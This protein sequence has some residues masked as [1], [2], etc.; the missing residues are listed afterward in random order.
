MNKHVKR[1]VVGM[2]F[3]LLVIVGIGVFAQNTVNSVGS[4]PLIFS[5]RFTQYRVF[6]CMRYPAFPN[7]GENFTISNFSPALDDSADN[8]FVEVDWGTNYDR[9]IML[10]KADNATDSNISIE[11]NLYES[12]G[13]HVGVVSESGKIYYTFGNGFVYISDKMDYGYA[14]FTDQDYGYGGSI[15][16]VAESSAILSW[17]E[18]SSFEPTIDKLLLNK[19]MLVGIVPDQEYTGEEITP[20][21]NLND[22]GTALVLGVDYRVLYLNNIEAGEATARVV[23]IGDY[24]GEFIVTFNI[25]NNLV[26]DAPNTGTQ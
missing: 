26:P 22:H 4:D 21:L 8:F 14:L 6:D 15:S 9:Y 3:A 23:G 24:I 19:N 11:L 10:N 18:L 16:G 25:V 20:T 13:S 7:V 17:D 5:I 12:D 1:T 2:L